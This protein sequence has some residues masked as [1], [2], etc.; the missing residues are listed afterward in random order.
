M[1]VK[2]NLVTSQETILTKAFK[3][4][5]SRGSGIHVSHPGHVQNL[6]SSW[7]NTL[8]VYSVT[9][10]ILKSILNLINPKQTGMKCVLQHPTQCLA[11][12][13]TLLLI[14]NIGYVFG[15][16]TAFIP[17]TNTPSLAGHRRLWFLGNPGWSVFVNLV[18]WT[19]L[20][21]VFFSSPVL[22]LSLCRSMHLPLCDS[23][24]PFISRWA[25]SPLSQCTQSESHRATKHLFWDRYGPPLRAAARPYL[26]TRPLLYSIL[27]RNTW[28][29]PILPPSWSHWALETHSD[30]DLG[31]KDEGGKGKDSHSSEVWPQFA[32]MRPWFYLTSGQSTVKKHTQESVHV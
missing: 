8:P 22:P 14:V 9:K 18:S 24:F 3:G 32:E 21:P 30:D 26:R 4:C 27:K 13:T 29:A 15:L 28:L 10:P 23:S 19:L 1:L 11:R 6:S 12:P 31:T 17:N 20:V 16:S 7:L 5:T 2:K 25:V